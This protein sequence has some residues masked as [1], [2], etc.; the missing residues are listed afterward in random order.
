MAEPMGH[1]D[2]VTQFKETKQ[3]HLRFAIAAW[4]IFLYD[5]F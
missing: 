3:F 4:R 2:G 1:A 5:A